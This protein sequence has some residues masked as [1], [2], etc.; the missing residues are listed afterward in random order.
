MR[1]TILAYVIAVLGLV[2]VCGGVYSFVSLW[3]ERAGLRLRDHDRND[4][5]R[6]CYGRPSPGLAPT[7]RDCAGDEPAVKKHSKAGLQFLDR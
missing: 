6:L 1:T 7:G 3:N 4:L 2:M 5:W